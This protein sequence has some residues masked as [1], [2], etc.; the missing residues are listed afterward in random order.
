VF[1]EKTHQLHSGIASCSNHS[2]AN[3]DDAPP[4]GSKKKKAITE[5]LPF[6]FLIKSYRFEYWNLLRAPF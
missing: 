3:H 2:D 6:P 1:G 4:L 5:G